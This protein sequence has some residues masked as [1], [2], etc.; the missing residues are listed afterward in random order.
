MNLKQHL[1][2][3]RDRH[4]IYRKREIIKRD[5]GRISFANWTLVGPQTDFLLRY[6]SENFPESGRPI[7]FYSVYGPV[8]ELNRPFSGIR[9]FYTLENMEPKTEHASCTGRPEKAAVW[10]ERAAKY[11]EKVDWG[12]FD[13]CFGY[14]FTGAPKDFV[15]FPL[16]LCYYGEQDF[17]HMEEIRRSSAKNASDRRP[18]AALLASHDFLGTR[19]CICDRLEKEQVL[20]IRYA[21]KWRHN[22][23]ELQ[24]SF[25]D[26]KRTFL[27]N[28]L[29][30]ICPENMDAP[31]Y[32]TEKLFDACAA[33]CI[34]IYAGSGNRPE[35]GIVNPDSMILWDLDGDNTENIG[36]IRTLLRDPAAL[37]AF[38]REPIFTEQ[39]MDEIRKRYLDPLHTAFQKVLEY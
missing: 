35:E 9:V 3:I 2:M 34:P 10:A 1:S 18:E 36:R 5:G 24:A 14:S 25:H 4:D 6:L 20:P 23:D 13:L 7:R 26:D 31:G 30:N 22:T 17:R 28:F 12:S 27:Q 21:G 38:L 32:V 19:A 15:Q 29:F 39:A 33:G 16:W 8:E 37:A 11:V